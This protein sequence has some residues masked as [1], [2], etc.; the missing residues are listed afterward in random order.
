M[1]IK[2]D[3]IKI[4]SGEITN[5]PYIEKIGKLKLK[6]ILS[7]GMSNVLEISNALKILIKNGTFFFKNRFNKKNSGPFIVFN[8]VQQKVLPK[9]N[10]KKFCRR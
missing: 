9:I 4:P 6:V 7:T 2:V 3:Y 1:K 10:K 8:A 5:V